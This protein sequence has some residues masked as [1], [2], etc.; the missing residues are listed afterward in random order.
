M[1]ELILRFA[2]RS[3]INVPGQ[4]VD[5]IFAYS[6]PRFSISFCNPSDLM[7]EIDNRKQLSALGEFQLKSFFAE[8]NESTIQHFIN[9]LRQLYF[10]I[11]V[12][13]IIMVA[14]HSELNDEIET[15]EYHEHKNLFLIKNY[16]DTHISIP[17]NYVDIDYLVACSLGLNRS[18][19]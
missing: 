5:V 14:D 18:E 17:V 15:N 9:I 11:N 16:N 8:E 7:F 12:K 4:I 1:D 2:E 6:L 3:K 13:R 19:I 10:N